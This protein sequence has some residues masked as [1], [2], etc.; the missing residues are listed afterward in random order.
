MLF[1]RCEIRL[2]KASEYIHRPNISATAMTPIIDAV[3]GRPI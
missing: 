2:S 3:N 1:T